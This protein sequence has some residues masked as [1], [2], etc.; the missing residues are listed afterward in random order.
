MKGEER[1]TNEEIGNDRKRRHPLRKD[2]FD[3]KKKRKGKGKGKKK[4]IFPKYDPKIDR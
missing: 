2:S 3:G 4:R 1:L